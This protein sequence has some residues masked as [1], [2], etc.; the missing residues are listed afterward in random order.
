MDS[1]THVV[2]GA[3]TGE[4]IAGKKLGKKAMLWGALFNSLPDIDVATTAFMD[5]PDGLLAHRGFTH[6]F[7][8]IALA[9]P[10]LAW[11]L[12]RLNKTPEMKWFSW[13]TFIAVELLLHVIPDSLTSY[14][15]GLLEPFSHKRFS[16][17]LI[18]VA[19][20]FFT[21][22]LLV[23]FIALL[24]LKSYSTRRKVWSRW[25]ILLT[26]LYIVFAMYNKTKVNIAVRKSLVAQHM[27]QDR[28]ITTP[29]PFNNFLWYVLIGVPDGFAVT[30]YSIFDKDS[31]LAFH[32]IPRNDSLKATLPD[33][34]DLQ[35]LIRFSQG[36]YSLEMTNDTVIFNDLRFGQVGGWYD[37]SAPF[38]FR[39][40]VARDAS[41]DMVIQSGRAKASTSKALSELV[42]R[43]LRDK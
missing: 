38:V 31:A 33:D 19:D 8:F 4:I 24:I 15:T 29:T 20:P 7:A 9:A 3:V 13:T 41:N 21:L 27:P 26:S 17:D 23:S 11:M 22:P 40:K 32:F 28:M 37:P 12:S 6:S 39:Y 42:R 2:L 35:K 25:G 10:L 18:F 16:F 30:H 34:K 1:L 5:I 14:G 36:F 43:I